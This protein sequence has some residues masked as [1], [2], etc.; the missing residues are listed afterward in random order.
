MRVMIRRTAMCGGG[1]SYGCYVP[2]KDVPKHV[3]ESAPNGCYHTRIQLDGKTY[4]SFGDATR[5]AEHEA[6]PCGLDK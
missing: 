6:M 4:L 2:E 3:L 1:L 5:S